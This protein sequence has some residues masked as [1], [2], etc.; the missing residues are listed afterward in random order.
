ME[1]SWIYQQGEKRFSPSPY[2]T[3]L[4][5]LSDAKIQD[6]AVRNLDLQYVAGV[7]Q[8]QCF[9]KTYSIEEN[10][11]LH[12]R[13]DE[14]EYSVCPMRYVYSSVLGDSPAYVNEYQQNRAI[15]RLIQILKKLL[16]DRYSVE[17][18]AEQVFELFPYIR[19]AEKRQ[20]L[21][22]ALRWELPRS[23]ESYTVDGEYKYTNERWNLTF[24]DYETYAYAEKMAAMLM[25]QN[26]RRDI[27][28]ERVGAGG[29]RNCEF[30]PH[31]RYCPH[32]LFGIDYKG[33]NE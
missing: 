3:L 10:K 6:S 18:I 28:P 22:D 27:Y 25:N 1:L 9:D 24:L 14:L 20:M 26:G 19:K 29:S 2:I 17:E 4:D 32:A 23:E 5:K 16:K 7:P 21:D 33:E 15:V 8:H 30:C 11:D 31:A 12:L 13:E